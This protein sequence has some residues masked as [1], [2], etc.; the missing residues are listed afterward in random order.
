MQLVLK[1]VGNKQFLF[2][3]ENLDF[4][5]PSQSHLGKAGVQFAK[6]NS[7]FITVYEV[8]KIL[9]ARTEINILM[10]AIVHSIY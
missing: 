10:R 2:H 3:R 6:R 9:I 4:V 1:W 8:P 5:A 7:V